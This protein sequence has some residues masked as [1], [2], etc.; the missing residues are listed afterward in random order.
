MNFNRLQY[1]LAA[2]LALLL[3]SIIVPAQSVLPQLPTDSRI[4]HGTL[5]CGASYYMVTDPVQKG[6]AQIA[7]VQKGD[8]LTPSKEVCPNFLSRMGVAPGPRGYLSEQDGNTV[9][10]FHDVR[11]YNPEVLDSV[12]LYTFEKMAACHAPQAVIVSGDIDAVELKKKM[13]IFSL[14]VSRLPE[15]PEEDPYLWQTRIAPVVRYSTEGPAIVSAAYTCP[16]VPQDDMNTAQALVTDLF[17]LEF[18]LLLGHRLEVNLRE[19]GIPYGSID[20]ISRRSVDSSEDEEYAVQVS[21]APEDLDNTLSVLSRTIAEI[22]YHGVGVEEYAESKQVLLPSMQ[23]RAA[24]I[25]SARD[26]LTRCMAHYLYGAQLAPYSEPLRFFARKR[27]SDSTETRLFNQYADALLGFLENLTLGY[28][29]VQPVDSIDTEGDILVK[30]FIGYL[31]GRDKPSGKDYRWHAADTAGLEVTCPKVRIKTEKAE[32]VSGGTVWTF[33]NGIRVIYK[34]VKGSG[35]FNYALQL[36]GGLSQIGSLKEGE[37][38]YIGEML[39]LYDVAGISAPYFSGILA[40][41]GVHMSTQVNLNSMSIQGD[42][43]SDQLSLVLKSLLGLA[44]HRSFNRGAYD[45]FCRRQALKPLSAEDALSLQMTPGY[46]YIGSPRPG[47]LC[48]ETPKKAGKFFDDRFARINDGTLIL[49]GDLSPEAAKRHLQRYLGGFRTLRGGVAR[50]AVEMRSLSGTSTVEMPGPTFYVMMDAEY[51]MTASH[52]YTAQIG[53]DALKLALV[54]HLADDG[55]AADVKLSYVVQPQERFRFLITCTP[56][57]DDASSGR[58]LTAVRAALRELAREQVDKA[59]LKAWKEGL[60]ADI[61]SALVTPE[62]FVASLLARYAANKD[63]LTYY[64]E[65]ISAITEDDV[66][67]FLRAMISGGRIET[68]RP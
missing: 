53:L 37:G 20:F 27:V 7:L 63:V 22:D 52:F 23:R 5:G 42:A 45:F 39:G 50:K 38:A 36:N 56:Y 25:P 43:P 47:A 48:A 34:Q 49:C 18:K 28:A 1:L 2:I 67:E 13:D 40:A 11:F 31:E 57:A 30:Y 8:S 15:A 41:N 54:R 68:V 51:A 59:D 32:P 65:T 64:D 24:Q 58:A 33:T 6:Y 10:R 55:F 21:V 44:N 3:Q 62:A 16:R 19:A 60:K 46:K 26:Y 9:Y 61:R 4:K 14:L 66:R 17:S 12:L 35:R 29:P